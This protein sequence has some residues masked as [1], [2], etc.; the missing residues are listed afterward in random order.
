MLDDFMPRK[1]KKVAPA[2]IEPVL[3]TEGPA[4]EPPEEVET[5][6]KTPHDEPIVIGPKKKRKFS[7]KLPKDLSRKQ[8]MIIGGVAGLLIA[9]GFI[10]WFALRKKPAPPKPVVKQEV[11]KE[12]PKPTTEAARLSG[13]QVPIEL[14][15]LPVTGVM[16]ENSPDARPQSGLNE[17]GVVFEAIAE[18]GITRF[19]ALFQ[20]EQP[21]YIGPVRS[22]RPYYL[23]FLAPF[24]AGIAHAGGSGAALEQVRSGAFKDLDQF[25]NGGAYQRVDSR[26]APHNLYTSRAQ[27][28]DLQNQKG[29]GTS[30]FKSFLRKAEK[31]SATVTAKTIDL[32]ISGYLYDPHYDYD[33]ASNTYKR[34]EGGKPHTDEKSGIQLGP[35]VVVALVMPQH[36]EGIYSVYDDT[37]S[38]KA[39]IFQDGTVTEGTWSKADRNTQLSLGDANGSPLPINPGQ[40]WFS[41]VNDAGA[42]SY[43]P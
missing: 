4:P 16:I 31:P 2:K 22:V 14:N 39:F 10:W 3:S 15:K 18:G 20:T 11:K 37:G 7:L 32:S 17:A 8:I 12:A 38:G 29:W 28:L 5:D 35:K 25:Y 27:L 42:V 9:G 43:K 30:N 19:L 36:Y 26:Y 33:A 21:V 13:V 34:S 24:D 23:D 40:T 1:A 41:L 6:R